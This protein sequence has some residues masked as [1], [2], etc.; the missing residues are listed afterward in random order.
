MGQERTKMQVFDN[1]RLWYESPTRVMKG[2]TLEMVQ[3]YNSQRSMTRDKE[4]Y[5]QWH[6]DHLDFKVLH[7][8]TMKGNVGHSHWAKER[9]GPHH[10]VSFKT[11]SEVS[12]GDTILILHRTPWYQWRTFSMREYT[13]EGVIIRGVHIVGSD[14]PYWGRVW[15]FITR[16]F[17]FTEELREAHDTHADEEFANTEKAIKEAWAE[18]TNKED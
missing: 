9:V 15:N 18:R 6:P 16:K 10:V 2:V 13:P 1:G 5:K 8:S 11:V 3:W 14:N 17:L 12:I 4:S 7:E